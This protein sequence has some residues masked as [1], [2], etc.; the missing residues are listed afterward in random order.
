[1]AVTGEEASSAPVQA[2]PAPAL[3]FDPALLDRTGSVARDVACRRCGYNV[4]GLRPENLC[5][6]C[7]EPIRDSLRRAWRFADP[8]WR[9]R[10]IGGIGWLIW[11]NVGG[12]MLNALIL[13]PGVR[14]ISSLRAPNKTS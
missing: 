6:E 13:L 4:R 9:R 8:A 2:R 7:A 11:T 3:D 1:M 12:C 5:P 14:L 10:V